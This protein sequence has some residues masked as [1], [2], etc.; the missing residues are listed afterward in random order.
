[1]PGLR[2]QLRSGECGATW[3]PPESIEVVKDSE[4]LLILRDPVAG[5]AWHIHASPLPFALDAGHDDA[6]RTDLEMSA[7]DAFDREWKPPGEG[8]V[9]ARRRTED[10]TWS[11]VIEQSRLELHGGTALRLLRRNAYQPGREIVTGHLIVP[12]AMGHVDFWL[13][14]GTPVTGIRETI[15]RAAMAKDRESGLGAAGP[16]PQKITTEGE[17]WDAI[18]EPFLPQATYDDPNLDERF[19]EHP[20]TLVRQAVG[21]LCGSV[22]IT[23]AAPSVAEV[24]RL[25]EPK[26]AFAAPPRYVPVPPEVLQMHPTLRVLMRLGVGS[27]RRIIEVKRHEDVRLRRGD[28]RNELC[29]LARN[30]VAGWTREGATA[31]K[32]NVEAINDFDGRPQVQ[33][34]VRMEAE[35]APTRSLFRWWVEPD[36]V[37]FRLGSSAPPRVLDTEHVALLDGVQA[38]WRRLD[39]VGPA[40]RPW[41]RIW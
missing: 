28:P 9:P 7:R 25:E 21:R 10:P 29:A 33:Q 2:A 39:A 11:P 22:A 36:G 16:D 34:W 19:P 1:M 12:T 8:T 18:A 14:I 24:I 15:V 20:L 6:L 31:I 38:S 32:T 35:G 17:V 40:R 5:I 41:W 4:D 30:T 26:C 37:I 13:I 27:W 23:H 3:M